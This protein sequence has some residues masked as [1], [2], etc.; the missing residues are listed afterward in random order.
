[1]ICFEAL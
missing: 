1:V